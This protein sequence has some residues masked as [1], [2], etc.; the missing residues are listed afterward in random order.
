MPPNGP[1]VR[2]NVS[3]ALRNIGSSVAWLF[4]CLIDGFIDFIGWLLC[5]ER[6]GEK[7]PEIVWGGGFAGSNR[8]FLCTEEM[9]GQFCF[10][11]DFFL[12]VKSNRNCSHTR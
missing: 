12:R 5:L 3:R 1:A 7:V 2:I 9:L 10:V 8:L 11:P 4:A 6:S